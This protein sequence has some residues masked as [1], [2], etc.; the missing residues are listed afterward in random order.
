MKSV[1]FMMLANDFSF[2]Y[3]IFYYFESG[4]S[5]LQH[6]INTGYEMK[7]TCG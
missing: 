5:F 6:L 4:V 1:W 7:E 2:W 3:G